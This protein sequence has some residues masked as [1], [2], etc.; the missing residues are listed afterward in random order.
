MYVPM[1]VD[2]VSGSE[3]EEEDWKDV[4]EGS[5]RVDVL[6]LRDDGTLRKRL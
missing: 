3:P 1:D 5:N 2:H 6:P 4:D